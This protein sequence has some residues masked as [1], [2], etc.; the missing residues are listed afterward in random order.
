M[1]PIVFGGDTRYI[2]VWARPN[3]NSLKFVFFN[4]YKAF[5]FDICCGYVV[6]YFTIETSA[7]TNN[8]TGLT[9][10]ISRRK[11]FEVLSYL[12]T[13]KMHN[14]LRIKMHGNH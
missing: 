9:V 13:D 3:V 12:F 11:I 2:D 6:G 1:S 7:F 4:N 5:L 14:T 8:F 10:T